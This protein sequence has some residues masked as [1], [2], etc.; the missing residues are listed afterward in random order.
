MMGGARHFHNHL[1][2]RSRILE[3]TQIITD[4]LCLKMNDILKGGY[5][6][7]EISRKRKKINIISGEKPVH[8]GCSWFL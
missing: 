8:I 4:N 5:S 3:L 6:A 7:R 1:D 2:H